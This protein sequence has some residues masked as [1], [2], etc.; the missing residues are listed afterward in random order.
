MPASSPQGG[1]WAARTP[2][3]VIPALSLDPAESPSAGAGDS[4]WSGP[5][6]AFRRADDRLLVSILVSLSATND[7][8]Y[9]R[10][11]AS[12]RWGKYEG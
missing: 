8:R 2:P 10:V 4:G 3:P 6:R 9:V 12:I 7:K 11:R 5:Q 1:E